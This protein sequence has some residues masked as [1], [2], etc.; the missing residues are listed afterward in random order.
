MAKKGE[1][2]DIILWNPYL[3][4]WVEYPISWS[5]KRLL[6]RLQRGY[7]GRKSNLAKGKKGKGP[8]RRY[9]VQ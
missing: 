3:Q 9:G 4:K 2:E 6:K 1:K 7:K 5:N 8:H